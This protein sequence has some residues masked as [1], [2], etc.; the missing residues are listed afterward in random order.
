MGQLVQ[1][2]ACLVECSSSADAAPH[3]MDGGVRTEAARPLQAELFALVDDAQFGSRGAA[4]AMFGSDAVQD[5]ASRVSRA[6]IVECLVVPHVVTVL[7]LK[8]LMGQAAHD[9]FDGVQLRHGAFCEL[10]STSRRPNRRLDA[11]RNFALFE[12]AARVTRTTE[13][14]GEVVDGVVRVPD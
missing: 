4:I 8:A 10:P 14:E 13:L 6:D 1:A 5:F 11:R 7:Y 3:D 12:L 9:T 2:H